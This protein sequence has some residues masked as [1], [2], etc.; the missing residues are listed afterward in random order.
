MII[1]IVVKTCI[2]PFCNLNKPIRALVQKTD[3]QNISD[4]NKLLKYTKI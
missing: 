3:V 2:D 1:S 4:R